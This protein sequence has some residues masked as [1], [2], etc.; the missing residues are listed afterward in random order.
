MFRC[1]RLFPPASVTSVVDAPQFVGSA[2]RSAAPTGDEAPGMH[3]ER[4]HSPHSL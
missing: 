3:L 4:A 1:T 2:P